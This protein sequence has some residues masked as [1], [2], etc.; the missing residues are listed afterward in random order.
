VITPQKVYIKEN[1]YEIQLP[2]N[3]I[4]KNRVEKKK[5]LKKLPASLTI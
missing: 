5:S 1:N 3:P 4:L 2:I